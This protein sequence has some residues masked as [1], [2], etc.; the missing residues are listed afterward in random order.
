ME[1]LEEISGVVGQ[2]PIHQLQSLGIL[3]ARHRLGGE[4]AW[5]WP[6]GETEIK[7]VRSEKERTTEIKIEED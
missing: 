6:L 5:H 7:A 3:G 2:E 1:S 4:M